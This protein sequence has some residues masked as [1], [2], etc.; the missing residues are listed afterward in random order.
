MNGGQF[1]HRSSDHLPPESPF[2]IGFQPAAKRRGRQRRA[3]RGDVS[4]LRNGCISMQSAGT[5]PACLW[6][7]H[8]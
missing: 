5:Y 8:K 1:I 3:G 2:I 7:Y 4:A 6:F